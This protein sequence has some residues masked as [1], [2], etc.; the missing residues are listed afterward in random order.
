MNELERLLEKEK[1]LKA[2]IQAA[3][4]KEKEK[5]RKQDTRR[6]ILIGAMILE[7][8]KNS[9]EYNAKILS[10][11]DKYLQK[12]KDRELFDLPLRSDEECS[13]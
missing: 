1:Q 4:S 11:L 6:K 9:E 8:M 2:K 3:K 13:N 12:N 5:E 7:G 10:N